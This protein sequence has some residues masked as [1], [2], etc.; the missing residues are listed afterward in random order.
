VKAYCT[1]CGRRVNAEIQEAVDEMTMGGK[2]VTFMAKEL[3]CKECGEPIGDDTLFLE[4][5]ER[6][7]EILRQADGYI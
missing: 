2:K 7:T 4:N 5:I 6:A 1:N 3:I